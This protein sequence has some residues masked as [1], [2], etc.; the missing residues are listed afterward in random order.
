MGNDNTTKKPILI[1]QNGN[2]IGKFLAIYDDPMNPDSFCFH[3]ISDKPANVHKEVMEA[4]SSFIG[5]MKTQPNLKHF[6]EHMEKAW[7]KFFKYEKI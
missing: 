2:R 3:F 7:D 6:G 4:Y 1:D 5:Y